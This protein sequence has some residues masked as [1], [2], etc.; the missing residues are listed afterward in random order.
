MFPLASTTIP[1][2][3]SFESSPEISSDLSTSISPP[4]STS[5][6]MYEM[7]FR[8]DL[9]IAYLTNE[10]PDDYI[11]GFLDG[12]SFVGENIQ[13]YAVIIIITTKFQILDILCP[14]WRD[15][16]RYEKIRILCPLVKFL[17]RNGRNINGYENKILT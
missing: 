6:Y 10:L 5:S 12:C 8:G 1:M 11:H 15:R 2:C 13:T 14:S 17:I 4:I 9:D 16:I 7:G 3:T